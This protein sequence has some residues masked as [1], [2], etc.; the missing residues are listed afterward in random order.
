MKL[1]FKYILPLFGLLIIASACQQESL[2]V[3][4]EQEE[5]VLEDAA[6]IGLVQGITAHDGSHDNVVDNSSCF[7]IDFPYQLKVNGEIRNIEHVADLATVYEYDEIEIVYPVEVTF[8]DYAESQISN[9]QEMNALISGCSNGNYYNQIIRCIDLI[10]PISMAE[11][12]PDTRNFQTTVYDH[13]RITFTGL[14]R[15]LTA[16]SIVQIQFPVQIEVIGGETL[17]IDS[18]DQLKSVISSNLNFCF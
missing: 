1:I 9:T 10:Y 13:D 2:S 5:D 12:N 7:S 15:M 8:A 14:R 17:Q 18:N 3:I 11:Y 4:D 16:G 6:L